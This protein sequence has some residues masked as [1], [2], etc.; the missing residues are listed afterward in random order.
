MRGIGRRIGA[1]CVIGALSI[2]SPQAVA[3]VCV[4]CDVVEEWDHATCPANVDAYY[5]WCEV[6]GSSCWPMGD[7]NYDWGNPSNPY[8][9]PPPPPDDDE[10]ETPDEDTDEGTDCEQTDSC[11]EEQVQQK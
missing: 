9:D 3:T 2:V 1:M 5:E 8:P 11:S 4:D 7:C 10:D 6:V